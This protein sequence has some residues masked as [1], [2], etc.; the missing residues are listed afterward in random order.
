MTLS[1]VT[2]ADPAW[3]PDPAMQPAP[4]TGPFM[5]WT[6]E[7]QTDS[8][9]RVSEHRPALR[10]SQDGKAVCDIPQTEA[11]ASG[12]GLPPPSDTGA[13][14][15]DHRDSADSDPAAAALAQRLE[16][17][18]REAWEDG[19]AQ[20]LREGQRRAEAEHQRREPVKNVAASDLSARQVALQEQILQAL[21]QLRTDARRLHA[22]LERLALHLARQL[23]R[24]ELHRGG[25]VVARLV[26]QA[27]D[28]LGPDALRIV[29]RLHPA[30]LAALGPLVQSLGTN[31]TL[32]PA[33]HL[34]RGSVEVVSD[35]TLVQDLIE[36]RLEALATQLLGH[37]VTSMDV[38]VKAE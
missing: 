24:G 28:A 35:E 32:E 36:N 17:E 23:V 38:G 22:P 2:R 16:L 6:F 11:V 12:T 9:F 5:P 8:S 18:R 4:D 21:L 31:V 19:Y 34:L 30:D 13:I 29:V 15:A 27:L 7:V 10:V 14:L 33:D 1:E 25:E 20:G 37:T 3:R 26:S